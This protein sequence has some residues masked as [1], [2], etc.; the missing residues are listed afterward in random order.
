[1]GSKIALYQLYPNAE[2]LRCDEVH[3]TSTNEID[4]FKTENLIELI[5]YIQTTTKEL[6]VKE[7]HWLEGDIES[8]SPMDSKLREF[9]ATFYPYLIKS[10]KKL[11]ETTTES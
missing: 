3:C 5:N 2:M 4:N 7:T 10:M 11:G 9:G 1:M 8:L 6:S